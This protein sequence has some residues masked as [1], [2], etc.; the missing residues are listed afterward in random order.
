MLPC[1]RG[2][3][4]AFGVAAAASHVCRALCSAVQPAAH[5]QLIHQLVHSILQQLTRSSSIF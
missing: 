5:P 1:L 4:Q 2:P 3:L